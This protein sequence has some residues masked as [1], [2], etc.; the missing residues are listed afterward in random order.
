MAQTQI[1]GGKIGSIKNLKKSLKATGM[2][3][4]SW[5]PKEGITVRFLTE[6]DDW[7]GYYE[8]YDE[9]IRKSY[10]CIEG[11]CP[12]CATDQKRT[13]R[14]LA[15][16]LDVEKD[17]VIALLLPKSLAN[18]LTARYER[19]DTLMDRD[20]ELF[21]TGE[22]LDTEY[23]LNPEAPKKR[24]F[25]KYQ[26]IDLGDALQKA[27]DVVWG[28]S[29][30]DEDEEETPR[31]R[32]RRTREAASRGR[33]RP[34]RDEKDEE[35]ETEEEEDED[36]DE[37]SE[38][39]ESLDELEKLNL[40]ALKE[41]AENI[42][43]SIKPDKGKQRISAPALR[44]RIAEELELSDEDEEEDEDWEDDEDEEEGDD[45]EQY[46]EDELASFSMTELREIARDYEIKTVKKSKTELI[47]AILESQ[48][49]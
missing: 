45:Y 36:E 20:Y 47:E 15:N 34:T 46:T 38:L 6:P 21:K 37:E 2:G 40:A 27:W 49:E 16:A 17:K 39:P 14:Y 33:R 4:L 8:H 44:A 28:E 10:P 11:D 9:A 1:A 7:F 13:F 43:I 23:D 41:V 31:T 22:G 35:D 32:Q 18:R 25:S 12:G 26:L 48:E 5:I 24:A 29:V 42:G 19:N 3:P 30:T